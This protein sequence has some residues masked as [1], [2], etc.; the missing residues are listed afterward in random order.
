MTPAPT[1]TTCARDGSGARST[2]PAPSLAPP[3][4][5]APAPAARPFGISSFILGLASG[6]RGE[7]MQLEAEPTAHAIRVGRHPVIDDLFRRLLFL[8][9]LVVP[10]V[11]HLGIELDSA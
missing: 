2:G 1:T 9:D 7:G 4:L 8:D 11:D 5:A 6:D 10:V 3:R